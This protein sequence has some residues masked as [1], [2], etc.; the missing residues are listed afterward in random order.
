MTTKVKLTDIEKK[1]AKKIAEERYQSN[2]DKKHQ[3]QKNRRPK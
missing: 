1:V 3:R 2:R